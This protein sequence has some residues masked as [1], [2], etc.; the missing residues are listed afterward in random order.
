MEIDAIMAQMARRLRS[1][2]WPTMTIALAKVPCTGEQRATI[3]GRIS[4]QLDLT[5]HDA[6]DAL[7]NK[8]SPKATKAPADAH[9]ADTE[10]PERPEAKAPAEPAKAEKPKFKAKRSRSGK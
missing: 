4:S 2:E 9:T 10:P 1:G 5:R 7:T 8:P 3:R 6:A